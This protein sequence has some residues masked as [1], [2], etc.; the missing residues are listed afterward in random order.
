MKKF[1]LLFI[2]LGLSF[3]AF[4]QCM[5]EHYS[6]EKRITESDMVV[7]GRILE[8][9]SH[10][11][12]N[13]RFIYT[14]YQLEVY[15][16]FKGAL[17]T[18]TIEIMTEG[19]R[20]DL[21]MMTAHPSFQ[22]TQGLTGV[23]FLKNSYEM[24]EAD[25]TE[26]LRYSGMASE[27]SVITYDLD[28]QFAYDHEYTYGSIQKELYNAITAVT[29]EE[30]QSVNPV[31]LNPWKDRLRP[32]AT[33][34]ISSFNKDT[35]SAGAEE[36]LVINGSNFGS[37]RGNGAVQF[38]DANYGD[39]RT[40]SPEFRTSYLSWSDSKIEVMVPS[41]AGTGRVKV[42]NNNNESGTS[43]KNLTIS[44]SHLNTFYGSASI[45]T[46]YFVTDHVDDNA[47]GGY[48]W[49]MHVA[50]KA[51]TNAVN[52]FMRALETWRC[53]TLMNWD[54]GTETTVNSIARDNVNLVRMTKFTDNKLGVCY[55]FWSGCG[56]ST[57]LLWY[58]TELDIEFDST[59]NWYYGT[60]T[61]SGSQMDFES[62]ATHE[63]GH[64]HQLG[65]VIDNKKIMHYSI[66]NGE[67]KTT[68]STDDV[69]G[70]TAVV[71][72][73]V[74]SNF[75]G[76]NKLVALAPNKCTITKPQA[77]F[78]SSH[79][80]ACPVDNITVT[81]SS[82]G[83][84]STYSWNFGENANPATA[85]GIGPHTFAYST[86]GTKVVR[87]I[88]INSFGVDTIEKTIVVNPPKP[89]DPAPYASEDS[90]CIGLHSYA[91]APVLNAT[92]YLWMLSGGGSIS[93]P[94]TDTLVNVNWLQSG[95]PHQVRI[96]ALNSCGN[97]A[98]IN[99]PVTV[100]NKAVANFTQSVDARTVTFTNTSTDASQY[101][102]KFGDGDSS[103]ITAPVHVYPHASSYTAVLIAKNF[104]SQSEKSSNLVTM[105]GAGIGNNSAHYIQV[106]PN[107]F[108]SFLNVDLNENIQN[109]KLTIYDVTG[110]EV[111]TSN[112]LSSGK[113]SLD[114]SAIHPGW[115]QGRI[116]SGDNTVLYFKVFKQ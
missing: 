30:I 107:P 79:S 3:S 77:N 42:L 28:D 54:V 65:H 113:N 40:F 103:A 87:L 20:I 90:V 32:L 73:S 59:K 34:V 38:L 67:R 51:R 95:G 115:Y 52:S 9:K 39:G 13:S 92:S 99:I 62:V 97:S 45:D 100:F 110:R 18:K 89:A 80:A 91:I 68:L 2:I 93:G 111:L 94:N 71:S 109:A 25:M 22:V 35:I 15:R 4:S 31:E 5:V 21:E 66:G 46:Q 84:V 108:N 55:S 49:Q 47:K 112:E 26:T 33:P 16:I 85:T 29:K 83:V 105:N 1:Y 64:G 63:L 37:T 23:F 82:E 57:T 61:P 14:V 58:V 98:T 8:G 96:I 75:C 50:F 88:T 114:L 102:W 76:P 78:S 104:C 116:V 19:G 86:F 11:K 69:N 24:I 70:A 72:R 106:Y 10:Y 12:K 7:E 81:D 48:S 74:Q 6:L 101:L 44:Y 53:G 60:G 17:T 27:Q 36:V 56:S 43:S 41:R